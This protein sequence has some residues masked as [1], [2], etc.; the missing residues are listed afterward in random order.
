MVVLRGSVRECGWCCGKVSREGGNPRFIVVR[1]LQSPGLPAGR[2]PTVNCA[3]CD[4]NVVW[5][6]DSLLF[7]LMLQAPLSWG[8]L[9]ISE[10][11]VEG[12]T[13]PMRHW[14]QFLTAAVTGQ[15]FGKDEKVGSV[16]T[17][18]RT[19]TLSQEFNHVGFHVTT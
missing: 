4:V 10:S 7:R 16:I 18:K 14:S 17:R 3:R 13:T 5:G 1:N 11:Q 9:P 19:H 6:C 12:F 2:P 15:P 8:H